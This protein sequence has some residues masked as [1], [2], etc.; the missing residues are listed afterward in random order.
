MWWAEE[1]ALLADIAYFNS[2]VSETTMRLYS[3]QVVNQ[4]YDARKAELL[5]SSLKHSS[6]QQEVAWPR[7]S[8]VG[9]A[10]I[11]R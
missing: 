4:N 7:G 3:Q 6:T 8:N 2:L 11:N 1:V 5:G 9:V 10:T